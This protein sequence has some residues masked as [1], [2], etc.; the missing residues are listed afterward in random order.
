MLP[1]AGAPMKAAAVFLKPKDVVIDVVCVVI[2][3]IH[4]CIA[5]LSLLVGPHFVYGNKGT[6]MRASINSARFLAVIHLLPSRRWAIPPVGSSQRR[7]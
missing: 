4:F 5:L 3:T 7:P 1:E 2:L 6:I